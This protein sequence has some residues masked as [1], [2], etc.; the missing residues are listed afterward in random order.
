MVDRVGASRLAVQ[1]RLSTAVSGEYAETA[2]LDRKGQCKW[3]L[4]PAP[5]AANF[6]SQQCPVSRP[7]IYIVHLGDADFF[8]ANPAI[9]SVFVEAHGFGGKALL[10][11]IGLHA[12]A[13][14]FHRVVLRDGILRRMLPWTPASAPAQKKIA[15]S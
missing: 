13:A 2:T 8:E 9:R 1:F 10:T 12:G 5:G 3:P 14:L 7:L 11:L 15:Q 4:C 6:G